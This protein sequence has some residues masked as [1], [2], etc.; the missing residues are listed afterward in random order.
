M[1]EWEALCHSTWNISELRVPNLHVG[2]KIS[3][4]TAREVVSSYIYYFVNE[5]T[6]HTVGLLAGFIVPCGGT[7]SFRKR[8][9]QASRRY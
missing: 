8:K 3:S 6:S 9:R 5:P 2:G 7:I 4:H 1:V